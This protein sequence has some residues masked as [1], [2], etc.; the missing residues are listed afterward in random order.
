VSQNTAPLKAVAYVAIS[1]LLSKSDV[2]TYTYP[3]SGSARLHAVMSITAGN[4]YTT[5][6]TIRTAASGRKCGARALSTGVGAAAGPLNGQNFAQNGRRS[7]QR[8]RRRQVRKWRS[9]R[10]VPVSVSSQANGEGV[11][12]ARGEAGDYHQ[13]GYD[14][15]YLDGITSSGRAVYSSFLEDAAVALS[16]VGLLARGILGLGDALLG[17]AIAE[18]AGGPLVRTVGTHAPERA[19]E[20]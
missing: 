12:G 18:S 11:D 16:G 8:R 1:N 17:G 15:W 7:R 20:R 3:M 19:A 2:G 9:H 13:R 5:S 10:G 14:H 4:I 6:A